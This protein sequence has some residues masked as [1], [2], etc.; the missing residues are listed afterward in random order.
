[1]E[2]RWIYKV[3]NWV[4]DNVKHML[5]QGLLQKCMFSIFR[6]MAIAINSSLSLLS[7]LNKSSVNKTSVPG[8]HPCEG[9]DY[10]LTIVLPS[11]QPHAAP[12]FM[13]MDLFLVYL[14]V[15]FQKVN[16]FTLPVFFST[17]DKPSTEWECCRFPI[18]SMK[19]NCR[20]GLI[21]PYKQYFKAHIRCRQDCF[22]LWGK[23]KPNLVAHGVHSQ[24]SFVRWWR[25]RTHG[26][27][28]IHWIR[29]FYYPLWNCKFMEMLMI[30][31]VMLLHQKKLRVRF[32]GENRTTQESMKDCVVSPT[33]SAPVCSPPRPSGLYSAFS[34]TRMYLSNSQ[35]T[36][37]CL[38][39][40][41]TDRILLNACVFLW[42][43]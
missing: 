4:I 29:P 20:N 37:G 19:L 24:I 32:Y 9:R 23:Q 7:W 25:L 28:C 11:F 35:D 22:A 30:E 6:T 38:V 41:S 2:E 10:T 21:L 3:S 40:S 27:I 13:W 36:L 14:D 31:G 1:M 34:P 15:W 12:Y 26:A 39:Y 8:S 18:L 16:Y 17:G 43:Q 5:L 42:Y 33:V